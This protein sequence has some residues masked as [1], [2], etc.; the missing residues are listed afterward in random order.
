MNNKIHGIFSIAL[1][2]ISLLIALL[3]VTY[4]NQLMGVLYL[5]LE[6]SLLLLIIYSYCC[7][8]DC[9]EHNCGH[10]IPGRIAMVLPKRSQGRYSTADISSLIIAFLILLIFP[11]FWLWKSTF[12]LVAFWISLI[13]AG[14][15]I[16][17]FVCPSCKNRNCVLCKTKT[18]NS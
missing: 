12:L 13:I 9:K 3:T 10:V 5:L 18:K 4:F 1:I 16:V 15:D 2:G 14:I 17:L 6:I 8:C 11:Q 7:K